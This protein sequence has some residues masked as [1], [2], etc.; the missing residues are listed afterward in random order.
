METMQSKLLR[1]QYARLAEKRDQALRNGSSFDL[2]KTEKAMMVLAKQIDELELL[3]TVAARE[4]SAVHTQAILAAL[5][6]TAYKY[7][8]EREK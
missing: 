5:Q 7:F 6:D 4:Q 8:K 1:D 3:G 2:D